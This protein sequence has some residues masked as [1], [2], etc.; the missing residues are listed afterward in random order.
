M[1]PSTIGRLVKYVNIVIALALLLALA[2]VYWFVW[3]PLP[4]HSG[5]IAAGV[6]APVSV[7]FDSLG[8]PHIRA[9]SQ[10][11]ALFAQGYI[12]AQDRLWQ[13]DA[14][15]R[16]SGGELAE[17]LGPGLL[18][19]DKES[20]RLRLRRIAEQAYLELPPEDLAAFAAYTR[21]VNAFLSSH[22]DNLPLEFTLLHYQPRPWSVID[23]VLLCLHMFRNLT[24]TFRTE[25]V[26]SNMLAE[27][28]AAKVNFLFPVRAGWEMQPGSNAWAIAGSHTAS[29]KPLLCNDMHLEYSIPG[30][31][32][33]VHL[34]APGLDVA[35]VSLPGAP[36]VTVGHNQRIA[37]GITNL[38]FD[39]QDL[40]IERFDERTGNYLF[41]GQVE[42]AR[43]ER[44]LIQVKGQRPVELVT[45]VTRHGPILLADGG[46]HL[47]LRWTAADPGVVQYPILDIN[48]AQDWG[49]FTSALRRW[50]GPGS[51][52]VYADVDGNIG[53]H[54]AGK[55]PKRSGYAGDV[56][57]DGSSG[58]FEWDGLI[59][60]EELPTS[61]NPPN[62]IIA[63]SNQ[64]PFPANYPYPVNGTFAPPDRSTQVRQLLSARNGWRA[65]DL[66]AVQKDVYSAFGKFL[67]A[68]LI[69]GY[70]KRHTRNPAM[71]DA[72]A[73]L[74]AWNGQMEKEQA[75][76]FLI[77]LVYQHVR[78][79][80]ADN[81]APG[82]GA[83]YESAMAPPVIEKLLG[84]RPSGWF[85]DYDDML[86]RAFVDALDEGSRIQ[87]RDPKRWRYGTFLNLTIKNPVIH[88]VPWLGKYFD[89]GPFPM[90]GS[91]T[92]VKQT[93]LGLAPS[94]RM[95]ADLGDWDRSL[96]NI[97]IGQSGQIFS[98]HYRDQWNDY[99]IGQSYPMQFRQVKA[100][101]TLEFRPAQ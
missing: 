52:F 48:R 55:L 23:S 53:Y 39:V 41:H 31:W 54:A 17:V 64:N 9:A 38:Q 2:L 33:M 93:S 16:Y 14:L 99:Y 59:P 11:D 32:Y 35:G 88:N 92:T 56:P 62:G 20:R 30:I 83:Q 47:A 65:Q 61:Y 4:Q 78:T 46:R 36:G 91:S 85:R 13:M 49:Q 10:V 76:P 42:Q 40:Y 28:D 63:T 19:S 37:W 26:K 82:K 60:F 80:I 71:E 21:G 100:S 72:V 1:N 70:E 50:G 101:G 3:R 22:L 74:K 81:A 97:Q 87:G 95:N 27:G 94:M 73:I 7:S 5:T 57:V 75:A 96:L 79:A 98:R 84:G 12:T 8:E 51:N 67:A 18:E 24:T 34:K 15:R 29:G 77:T 69:A 89:I 45:F 66:L 68:Q 86:L 44:E 6:A 90:S 43:T 58:Q 25:L